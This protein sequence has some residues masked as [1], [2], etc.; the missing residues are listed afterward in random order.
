[1]TD[2]IT[3]VFGGSFNPPH[4]AHLLA[5]SIVLARFDV[6]RILVVPTYRHPF[7]K[8]LAPYNDRVRMCELAMGWLPRV[9]VS[10]V[11]QELGTESRTLRT[12]EHLHKLHPNWNLRFVMGADLKVESDKWYGFDR[13]AEL[14]PPIVLGRVGV[15]YEGAPLAILPA[16]SSTEVRAM[17]AAGRWDEVNGVL[18][19]EVVAF[20]RT[21]K[22][23]AAASQS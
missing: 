12:I 22:L 11:E 9:E 17:I 15:I 18:A 13:I 7:A 5:L 21:N 14:A 10:R 23:Y 1:M 2:A 6:A 4:L 19:R 16:I 8:T 20:V 3:G